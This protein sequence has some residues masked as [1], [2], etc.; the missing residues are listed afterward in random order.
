VLAVGEKATIIVPDQTLRP[1]NDEWGVCRPGPDGDV[2]LRTFYWW[3]RPDDDIFAATIES[4][5]C[6]QYQH[7]IFDRRVDVRMFEPHELRIGIEALRPG[8]SSIQITGTTDDP[9]GLFGP[10]ADTWISI[11]VIDG[12][13][14]Q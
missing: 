4:C 3:P 6:E 7:E 11:R 2:R 13:G 9:A 14:G 5:N 10:E 8:D 1:L 12:S